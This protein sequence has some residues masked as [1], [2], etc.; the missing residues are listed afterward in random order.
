MRR[1]SRHTKV[2]KR[3]DVELLNAKLLDAIRS[4]DHHT[5]HALLDEGADVDT[6]NEEIGWYLHHKAFQTDSS[7]PND[8]TYP[9]PNSKDDLGDDPFC[10]QFGIGITP[11]QIAILLGNQTL[12][13][14]LLEN[15][16]NVH[17]AHEYSPLVTASWL[18]FGGIVTLLLR[19][20]AD[21][22]VGDDNVGMPLQA[23][24]AKGHIEI[25]NLLL[26]NGADIDETSDPYGTALT[27]ASWHNHIDIVKLLLANL[28]SV[29]SLY[30][31]SDDFRS[32]LAAA[33]ERGNLQVVELLLAKDAS[34]YVEE[35][36][37]DSAIWLASNPS[38]TLFL[39]TRDLNGLQ[40]LYFERLSEGIVVV[41]SVCPY[42]VA[43]VIEVI[44][45]RDFD[46][47][48]N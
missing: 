22:N 9:G 18:G 17:P 5:A 46:A 27:A 4:E 13:N 12:V 44:D 39:R 47:S 34:D 7:S 28:A 37:H 33:A 32:P 15:K 42:H 48:V 40:K 31:V 29:N 38:L 6:C 3:L 19:K 25:V 8:C 30:G 10:P 16:A 41:V 43:R 23:A 20:G 45:H 1:T 36:T 14:L 11:L 21:I 26:E 24:A 35:N 2:P